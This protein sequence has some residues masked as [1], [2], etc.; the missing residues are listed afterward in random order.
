MVLGDSVTSTA[1]RRYP[2]K[3]GFIPGSVISE[4]NDARLNKKKNIMMGRDTSGVTRRWPQE[5]LSSHGLAVSAKKLKKRRHAK[6]FK[7]RPLFIHNFLCNNCVEISTWIR[8][9][10]ASS[11]CPSLASLFCLPGSA[12]ST[13]FTASTRSAGTARFKA[14][15][16][17]YWKMSE[18]HIY[19]I[20]IAFKIICVLLRLC[21]TMKKV[22]CTGSKR[23]GE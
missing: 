7:G 11:F 8:P 16:T 5:K 3:K 18:K 15:H 22:N 1:M 9:A 20:I 23:L 4:N 19:S 14:K 13:C 10:S 21:R 6:R 17:G 12:H 2:R